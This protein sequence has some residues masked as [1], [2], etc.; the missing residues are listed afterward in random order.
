M[1]PKHVQIR[2]QRVPL[3]S[4][5]DDRSWSAYQGGDYFQFRRDE[6]TGRWLMSQSAE[7][8]LHNPAHVVGR[9]VSIQDAADACTITSLRSVGP[10]GSGYVP[11]ATRGR[12]FAAG[13]LDTLVLVLGEAA[14]LGYDDER[15]NYPQRTG[16]EIADAL[17]LA[18]WNGLQQLQLRHAYKAGR[19]QIAVE[20]IASGRIE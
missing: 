12:D 14:R 19:E 9:G 5:G 11:S 15:R 18:R 10:E 3:H 20:R 2:G 17:G 8:R 4:T 6:A 13:S 7:D 1:E 16:N